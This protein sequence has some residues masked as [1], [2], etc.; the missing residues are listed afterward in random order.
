M[1][2]MFKMNWANFGRK[3]V[4][5]P[6][7]G[8]QPRPGA[9]PTPVNDSAIIVLS[10]APD[11]KALVINT[12]L[13]FAEGLKDTDVKIATNASELFDQIE[14]PNLTGI[15]IA[16][17][18][19]TEKKNRVVSERGGGTVIVGG[20]FSKLVSRP[21]FNQYFEKTWSLPWKYGSYHRTTVHLNKSA[22]ERGGP[23]IPASYSQK[24]VAAKGVDK[25]SAWYLPGVGST[26]NKSETPV[27]FENVGE[28]WLGYT[29]DVN[30]EKG[31]ADVILSMLQLL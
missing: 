19:I 29:G 22:A 26:G 8:G 4:E 11:V 2:A 20:L 1:A 28:G 16:D 17:Q 3:Y 31:T 27:A 12:F 24:A 13:K 14:L 21:A 5:F 10:L 25:N 30:F 7:A 15:I 6:L 23:R 18:R 9:K